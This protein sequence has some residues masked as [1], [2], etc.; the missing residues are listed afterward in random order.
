MKPAAFDYIAVESLDQALALKARHGEDA[1]WL[2]GGQ[3]LLPAMN[4]RLAQ[5]A[6][7]LDINLLS[8]LDFISESNEGGLR[9]GALARYRSLERSTLVMRGQP[10]MHET[11]PNIA[12]PQIRNRGTLCGNLAHADPA[13]ELPAVMLALAARM[14]IR[15]VHSARWVHA[16]DFFVDIFTTALA[17]DEMLIEVELPALPVRTGTCFL[18]VARRRG[19]FAMMGVA[20]VVTLDGNGNCTQARLAYCNAGSTPVSAPRAAQCLVGV[21]IDEANCRAAA[22]LAQVEIDPPGNVH[23]SK[24]YQRH[25]AGVLTRRALMSAHA[26]AMRDMRAMGQGRTG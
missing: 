21:R 12:H 3:S 5:P 1:R 19:D 14:R 24:A 26:R 4:F 10:L 7:L 9:I 20:A 25:L 2:A 13:S 18:E 15:S 6:I 8:E 11:V 16:K 22:A 23:A 17:S